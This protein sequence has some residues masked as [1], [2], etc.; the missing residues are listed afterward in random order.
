MEDNV[1]KKAL[2]IFGVMIVAMVGMSIFMRTGFQAMRKDKVDSS[3]TKTSSDSGDNTE[4]SDVLESITMR[5]GENKFKMSVDSGKA[6][7]EFAKSTPFELDM[8]ES[9]SNEKFYEGDET[10]PTDKYKPFR[11]NAGDVMLYGDKTI[12]IFY[13]SFDTSEEYTYLGKIEDGDKLAEALGDSDVTVE[14]F[15]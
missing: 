15:K 14:F 13:K 8:V 1:K 2:I 11:I 6:G 4:E 10:L 3:Q 12:V 5:V 9:N 7:Q